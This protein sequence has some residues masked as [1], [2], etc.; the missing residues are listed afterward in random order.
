[1][2]MIALDKELKENSYPGRGI[3]IGRS[4]DG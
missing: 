2:E 3:V 1:M 4:A